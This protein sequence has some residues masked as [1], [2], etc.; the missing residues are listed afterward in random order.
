MLFNG[1][2]LADQLLGAV[3]YL[4]SKCVMHTDLKPANMVLDA[5]EVLR[6]IDFGACL[7]DAPGHRLL[8]D[9]AEL[10]KGLN[11]GTM[12]YRA[13]ELALGDAAF[14]RAVDIWS[15]GC[16]CFELAVLQPLFPGEWC[17]DNRTLVSGCFAMLGQKDKVEP[18]LCTL[19]NYSPE[20]VR[21]PDTAD[22]WLRIGSS[23]E[24]KR[25]ENFIY[26]MLSLDA[27]SNNR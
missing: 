23:A 24:T 7:V 17:H 21:E 16:L 8:Q 2:C 5:D 22:Y 4:H 14:G 27:A 15:L 9:P 13:I 11:Y 20:L 6:L 10:A 26:Q 19:P 1:L 18:R 3:Q 25:Y 12:P